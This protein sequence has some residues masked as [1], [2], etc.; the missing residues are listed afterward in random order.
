VTLTPKW[1]HYELDLDFTGCFPGVGTEK[2]PL[3]M[4]QIRLEMTAVDGEILIDDVELE[5]TGYK[6]PTRWVDEAVEA[7]KF[8]NLGIIR[9]IGM[10][11][12]SVTSSLAPLLSQVAY[13]RF[14]P[15]TLGAKMSVDLVTPASYFELAEY[16]DVEAYYCLP[17]ATTCEEI[18]AFLEYIGAPADVEKF[19]RSKGI[20][21]R[22][23]KLSGKS[24]SKSEMKFGL[25]VDITRWTIGIR[26]LLARRP[27]RTT[28]R[29]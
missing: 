27:R 2:A 8:A 5:G 6:N 14:I 24:I 1:E 28:N 21:S 11:R 13:T 19:E 4:Q 12:P 7:L 15:Q 20:L 17:Q 25:T 18:E 29:I 3:Q 10:H 9:R 26:C 16:L 22:G 23:W